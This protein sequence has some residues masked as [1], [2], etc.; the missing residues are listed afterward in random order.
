MSEDKDNK[1]PVLDEV[2]TTMDGRDITRGYVSAMDIMQP[3]DSVLRLRGNGNYDI[4]KEVLRDDQVMSMFQQRRLAVISRE[5]EVL[6]GGKSKAD[7]M[8]ADFMRDQ[9]MHNVRFDTVTDKMLYGV[10]YGYATSECM[11]ARDGKHI[12]L[13][14]IKVRDR[15]RFGF[16]GQNRLR[17]KTL[18]NPAGELLPDRKFWAFQTGADHD[19]EPYGLGLAHWLYWPL[20]FKRNDIKFWLVFLE[21]FGQPTSV[22]RY[23]AG[24]QPPEKQ[25]LLQ[26]LRD[27]GTDSGVIMPSGMEV[28]LLEA[29]R[30]GTGD[31]TSLYDR[32]DKAI[33]KV[34]IG[35]TASSEGTAGRLGND[36][37]Q[38]DVRLE[39]VKADADLVCESFNRGPAKWLTEWN[40]PN[41]KPPKVWR[42]VENPE[43]L[44]KAAERDAKLNTIGYRPTL[45]QIQDTYGGEYEDTQ[46]SGA[47]KPA[48]KKP[49][50]SFTEFAEAKE[51]QDPVN[52]MTERMVSESEDA[53]KTWIEHVRILAA[54]ANTLEQL[55]DDLLIAF[56][57]MPTDKLAM[58][59]AEGFSAAQ[60]AGR[61]NVAD[62]AGQL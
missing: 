5:W 34:I 37:L 21:K 62:E 60:A 59:M 32:M 28:E 9:L 44:N 40:F 27:I 48:E 50:P 20:F 43:D 17:L 13:E 47:Q 45:R 54:Q 38:N 19:D 58:I 24:A 10:F 33:A 6:P 11:W 23:P 2:A 8:A 56:G 36:D 26:T 49:A 30:S 41:A 4:Y 31:Y 25:S 14:S 3:T 52:D 16:D 61:F 53:I 46:A 22:G 1:Q 15:S 29:A 39:L 18:Q 7:K 12:A 55:R 35:Q 42:R 51:H 57:D